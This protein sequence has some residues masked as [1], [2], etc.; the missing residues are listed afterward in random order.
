MNRDLDEALGDVL[1]VIRA[2]RSRASRN[3]IFITFLLEG[4]A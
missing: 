4:G 2:E 3:R 1:A